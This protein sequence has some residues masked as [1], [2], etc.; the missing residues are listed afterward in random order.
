VPQFRRGPAL[1]LRSSEG[2]NQVFG[3][4]APLL[5]GFSLT[6]VGVLVQLPAD[7][8]VRWRDGGFFSL[9]LATVLYLS[10][11]NFATSAR[12]MQLG[13]D[14]LRKIAKTAE[15]SPMLSRAYSRAR[16]LNEETARLLFGVASTVLISGVAVVLVPTGPWS[17]VSV[18]RWGAIVIAG[19]AAAAQLTRNIVRVTG[20]AWIRIV[21]MR[22]LLV[23]LTKVERYF[24]EEIAS[25]ARNDVKD[26]T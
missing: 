22:E 24:A 10:S 17:N 15:S 26:A 7:S 12:Y 8:G 5:A 25:A 1:P 3:V 4:A 20:L 9:M 13:D 14:Q 11:L 16:E 19:V 2:T 18:V 21:W 23:P 6:L